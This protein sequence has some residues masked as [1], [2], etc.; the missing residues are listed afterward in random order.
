MTQE[1][2]LGTHQYPPLGEPWCEQQC[3]CLSKPR[4]M[5]CLSS[6][7]RPYHLVQ[8]PMILRWLFKLELKQ[9]ILPTKKARQHLNPQ[10]SACGLAQLC[11]GS[12]GLFPNRPVSGTRRQWME[13]LSLG[14]TT[15]DPVK[16]HVPLLCH[17]WNRTRGKGVCQAGCLFSGSGILPNVNTMTQVQPPLPKKEPTFKK[18]SVVTPAN[19]IY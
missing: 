2:C 17:P 8:S 1:P 12:T 3:L 7:Q 18:L 15:G 11:A 19:Y 13:Y 9:T 14:N 16:C 10:L 5:A 4:S 6:P